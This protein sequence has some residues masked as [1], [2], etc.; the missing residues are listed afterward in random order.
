M[1]RVA[2]AQLLVGQP[3]R[4]PRCD[5]AATVVQRSRGRGTALTHQ[6]GEVKTARSIY[7]VGAGEAG[8]SGAVP[9]SERLPRQDERRSR[10]EII[11]REFPEPWGE[12]RARDFGRLHRP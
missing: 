8:L 10:G 7:V 3:V 5:A 9:V 6:L 4:P 12:R 11:A 2:R 1:P